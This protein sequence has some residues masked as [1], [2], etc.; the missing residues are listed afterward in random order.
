MHIPRLSGFLSLEKKNVEIG[1]R[2]KFYANT[3]NGR[4]KQKLPK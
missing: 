3:E 2:R 4:K 1:K